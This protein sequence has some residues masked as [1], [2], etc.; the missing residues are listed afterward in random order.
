LC[1]RKGGEVYGEQQEE[2]LGV[3]D[4]SQKYIVPSGDSHRRHF[5]LVLFVQAL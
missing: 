5:V 3:S 1:C 4:S 2:W